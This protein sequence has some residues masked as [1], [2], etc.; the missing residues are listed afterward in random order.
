[1]G[2]SCKRLMGRKDLIKRNIICFKWGTKYPPRYVNRLYGM[3]SRRISSPFDLHCFTD[4]RKGIRSEVTCHD[5]PDLGVDHPRNV[6]GMWRKTAIWGAELGGITGT[7][8]FVDLDSVIVGN[9]DAFFEYGD[10]NDVILARNWLKPFQKLG[11]TTLFRF[12]VGAQPYLL[13]DFQQAPQA[14]AEQYQFEQHY[15]TQAVRNGVK[16]WPSPWVRH[17]RVHCLPGYIRRYFQAAKIPRGAR[18]I[19][20]PGEPNPEDALRGCWTGAEPVTAGEHLANL[21]DKEKRVHGSIRGHFC[22][23]QRPC[24]WVAEYWQE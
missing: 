15:V 1:M 11:Q 20:F 6:P 4:D 9:L 21:F 5:L 18:I 12:K 8:L 16:F 10:E 2:V 13:E 24:P 23:F 22:C 7:A 3:I 19:A 14:I 17:Y